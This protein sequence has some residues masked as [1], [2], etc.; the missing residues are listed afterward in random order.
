MQDD[1]EKARSLAYVVS[2]DEVLYAVVVTSS[3]SMQ[4]TIRRMIVILEDGV[5][6]L[7]PSFNRAAS[8]L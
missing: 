3:Q 4:K 7:V 2:D 6:R 5:E 1:L 8:L